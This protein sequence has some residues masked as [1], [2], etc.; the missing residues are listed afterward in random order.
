MRN[1]KTKSK[2]STNRM[3]YNQ[4]ATFGSSNDI[5]RVQTKSINLI[6]QSSNLLVVTLCLT[7][8]GYNKILYI[9]SKFRRSVVP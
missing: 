5:N 8:L 3:V 6:K 1:S 7:L 4:D 9:F 2:K